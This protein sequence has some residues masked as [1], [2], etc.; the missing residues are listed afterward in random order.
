MDHL[1][2]LREK[3]ARLRDEISQIQELNDHYR[4]VTGHSTEAQ[5]AHGQRHER[6]QTIQQELAHLR[7]LGSTIRSIEQMKE[8]HRSRL[9]LVKQAKAS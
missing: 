3:I 8:K 2:V 7:D 6:L 4:R 1:Q 9:H 5:V